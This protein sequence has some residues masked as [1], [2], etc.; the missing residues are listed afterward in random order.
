MLKISFKQLRSHQFQE[1][2]DTKA[3]S[4][5]IVDSH[6]HSEIDFKKL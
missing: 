4:V 2:T 1:K 5:A 3:I 6:L